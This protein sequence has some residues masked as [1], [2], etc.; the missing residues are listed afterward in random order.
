MGGRIGLGKIGRHH[1]VAEQAIATHGS[2]R[3]TKLYD[4]T[5]EEITLDQIERI[6]ISRTGR[7]EQDQARLKHVRQ[8]RPSTKLFFGASLSRKDASGPV[9]VFVR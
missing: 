3:T 4:R 1:G 5:G 9:R 6:A 7:L 8:S 2:P